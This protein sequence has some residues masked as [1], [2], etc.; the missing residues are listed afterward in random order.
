MFRFA[1]LVTVLLTGGLSAAEKELVYSQKTGK[2]E[3]DG[4]S[5]GNGYSGKGKG[6][7][8]PEMEK[9]KDTGPIPAGNY[10]I[11]KAFKHAN[12]G[13]MVMRLTPDGHKAHG[14]D[15]FLIHGDN[16]KLNKSA[17]EGCIILGPDIR[18]KIS[19]SGVTKLRVIKE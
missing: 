4:K 1:I 5:L 7:N 12:K 3:L 9:V 8:N 10:T 16:E 11:G 19:E 6:L 14:R 13:P 2:I 15:G 18:Q 17:S